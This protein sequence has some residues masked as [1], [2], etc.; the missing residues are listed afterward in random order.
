MGTNRASRDEFCG[1]SRHGRPPKLLLKKAKGSIKDLVKGLL[2][3]S[4]P[5]G[6]LTVG[7]MNNLSG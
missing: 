1:I 6:D 4:V 5:T 7:T 2:Y 3:K